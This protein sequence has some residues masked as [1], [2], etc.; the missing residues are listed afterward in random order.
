MKTN[1]VFN[2]NPFFGSR[3]YSQSGGNFIFTSTGTSMLPLISNNQDEVVL[4]PINAPLKKDDIVLFV[5]QDGTF[6]LHRIIKKKRNNTYVMR[7]DNQIINEKNITDNQIIAIVTKIIKKNQE[8]AFD[9]KKYKSYCLRLHLF[10]PF[11]YLSR[12]IKSILFRIFKKKKN[13]G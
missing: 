2:I 13:I 10:Y 3:I 7:G 8:I 11:K 1:I 5:R 4:S 12:K 6:V 9:N